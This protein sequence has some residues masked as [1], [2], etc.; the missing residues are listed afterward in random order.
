MRCFYPAV[1]RAC[2]DSVTHDTDIG[3]C[4]TSE[5][6]LSMER[7]SMLSAL[8]I[9]VCFLSLIQT[10]LSKQYRHDE[11]LQ[12]SLF[13]NMSVYE[14]NHKTTSIV[15][16]S[17]KCAANDIFVDYAIWISLYG[18]Y[19]CCLHSLWCTILENRQ[20]P[21]GQQEKGKCTVKP[22]F[23]ITWFERKTWI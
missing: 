17:T 3:K 6:C 19:V 10:S 15:L 9:V 2:G 23:N 12:D 21:S 5:F 16:F 13:W 4:V 1:G 14:Q 7:S 8:K 20:C 11:L 22:A 18:L